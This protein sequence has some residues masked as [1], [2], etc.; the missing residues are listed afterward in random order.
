MGRSLHKLCAKRVQAEKRCGKHSDGGALNL[1]ITKDGSKRWM[2]AWERI[3]K[4]REMGLGA[5]ERRLA[6]QSTGLRSSGK[7]TRVPMSEVLFGTRTD[8]PSHRRKPSLLLSRVMATSV[9]MAMA[10]AKNRNGVKTLGAVSLL[11]PVSMR[12]DAVPIATPICMPVNMTAV[13]TRCCATPASL[14][15]R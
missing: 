14:V 11:D 4:R 13:E 7:D 1:F 6:L 12:A 5:G 15:A 10:T 2:F 8:V 3:G 9:A